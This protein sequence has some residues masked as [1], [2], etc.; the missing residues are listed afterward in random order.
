VGVAVRVGDMKIF[1][2]AYGSVFIARQLLCGVSCDECKTYLT[3][4]GM[5]SPNILIYLKDYS[6][7]EQSHIN[8]SEKLVQIVGTSVTVT[9]I[10]SNFRPG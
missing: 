4:Q 8:S 3:S 9:S 1:V 10:I 2:V 5:L 7:T 6:D